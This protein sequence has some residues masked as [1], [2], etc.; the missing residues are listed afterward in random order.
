VNLIV[1][2]LLAGVTLA[3]GLALAKPAESVR[4]NI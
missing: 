4:A 1:P 3:G 2:V